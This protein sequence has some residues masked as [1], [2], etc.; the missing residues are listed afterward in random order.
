M[1][2]SMWR[3]L[4]RSTRL[5]RPSLTFNTVWHFIR[6]WMTDWL[7][8]GHGYSHEFTNRFTSLYFLSTF[9]GAL[10]SGG[11]IAWLAR[12]DWNVHRARLLTFLLFGV[13]TAMIVPAAFL[14]K[15]NLLLAILLIVAFGSL[16]LFPVYYSL[17]QELSA[18]HQGKVGGS[19]GFATWFTLS[20]FHSWVGGVLESAPERRTTIFCLVG[21]APLL[22]YFVLRYGW[23]QRSTPPGDSLADG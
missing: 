4:M 20:F 21:L 18:K 10:A 9:F 13:L 12:R 1:M 17:N 3:S 19:L 7:E 5:G 22:A 2:R 23:G 6:V 15:G 14:P 11:L 8:N 16:G